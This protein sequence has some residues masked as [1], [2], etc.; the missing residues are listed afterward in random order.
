MDQQFVGSWFD[1]ET[2][3][4][5]L[6]K[7]MN[8]NWAWQSDGEHLTEPTN[9][10]VDQPNNNPAQKCAVAMID[11]HTWSNSRCGMYLKFRGYSPLCQDTNR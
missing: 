6:K 2:F 7:D 11:A 1:D 3:W 4:I 5:G 10:G 9:W 8:G